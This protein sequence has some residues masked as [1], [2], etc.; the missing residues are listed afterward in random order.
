[1]FESKLSLNRRH[2]PTTYLLPP[3]ENIYVRNV[4]HATIH[5]VETPFILGY[6]TLTPKFSSKFIQNC[7]FPSLVLWY[8]VTNIAFLVCVHSFS[9]DAGFVSTS[10]QK[11]RQNLVDSPGMGGSPVEP[12]LANVARSKIHHV[13][14]FCFHERSS[15][16]CRCCLH[17]KNLCRS[18]YPVPPSFLTSPCDSST[19]R[20]QFPWLQA[21]I[22]KRGV[23]RVDPEG[24]QSNKTRGTKNQK[25]VLSP[26]LPLNAMRRKNQK[27]IERKTM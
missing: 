17:V 10:S 26:S 16:C 15:C 21:H 13:I 24:Q 8:A 19:W 27:G 11:I 14:G 23:K 20:G 9:C 1:M 3:P 6:L 7:L 22:P 25:Q 12:S 18:L 5:V 2:F 4:L